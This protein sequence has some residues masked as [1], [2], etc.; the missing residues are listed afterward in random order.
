VL[1]GTGAVSDSVKTQLQ[2]YTAAPVVRISGADRFATAV[3]VSK[4]FFTR[5][6][7]V[8]LATG[9][10]FPDALATVPAA[11]RAGAPLLLVGQATI[12]TPVRAELTRLFPPRCFLVGGTAVIGNAV[13]SQINGLLGKP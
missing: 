11:G 4:T 12:P 13:V 9:M 7:Q 6:P 1:G 3:A 8:Y 2:A 5:P 10:N